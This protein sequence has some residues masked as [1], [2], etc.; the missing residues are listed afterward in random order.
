MLLWL[1]STKSVGLLNSEEVRIDNFY[2]FHSW[3]EIG[4]LALFFIQ[5]LIGF[6]SFWLQSIGSSARAIVLPWHVFW[7]LSV[8]VLAIGIAASGF[9]EKLTFL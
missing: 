2:S 9:F 4:T 5:W 1:C 6:V 8:Y 7:G 3:L